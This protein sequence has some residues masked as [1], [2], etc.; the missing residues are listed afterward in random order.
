M[1]DKFISK[2]H[3]P[4][5]VFSPDYGP[6]QAVIGRKLVNE[7][8]RNLYALFPPWHGGDRPYEYLIHRLAKRGDAVLAYYFHDEILRPD[9]DHVTGSLT[10]IKDVATADLKALVDRHTYLKVVLAGL[11]LGNAPMTSVTGEFNDYDSI[12][13]VVNGNSLAG[14]MWH[15]I[16]TTHI[17]AGLE[18]QGHDLPQLEESWR[19]F[20]PVNHLGAL[21]GKEVYVY[22]SSSDEIIPTRFQMDYL[23][24][25]REKGINPKVKISSLGHYLTAAR[26][27]M[28]GEL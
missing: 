20:A 22:P 12:H 14:S 6:E 19:E 18:E 17:R 9:K 26:F 3:T 1:L 28:S 8:G 15:G 4:H 24:R 21:Q 2:R 10:R 11:S 27:L 16:R 5:D 13:M 23:E 25:L 7:T